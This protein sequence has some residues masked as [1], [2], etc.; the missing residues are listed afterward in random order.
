M[1]D[2]EYNFKSLSP[3]RDVILLLHDL[4]ENIRLSAIALKAECLTVH[5]VPLPEDSCNA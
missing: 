3:A 5:A 1:Q 4:E 2:G